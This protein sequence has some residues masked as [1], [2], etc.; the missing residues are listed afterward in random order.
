MPQ[1]TIMR[2]SIRSP[3]RL[4]FNTR[5]AV[6]AR[7]RPCNAVPGGMKE[8]ADEFREILRRSGHPSPTSDLLFAQVDARFR[9]GVEA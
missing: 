5:L 4:F 6:V 1:F 9:A 7:E 3:L 8:L 2:R